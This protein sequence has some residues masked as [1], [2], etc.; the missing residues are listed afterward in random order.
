VAGAHRRPR[1]IAEQCARVQCWSPTEACLSEARLSNDAQAKIQWGSRDP[2]LD[3]RWRATS[4][5]DVST[6]AF[7]CLNAPPH[8]H[9]NQLTPAPTAPAEARA[10]HV[11]AAICVQVGHGWEKSRMP[12]LASLGELFYSPS[13]TPHLTNPAQA[14]TCARGVGHRVG[15]QLSL[16]IRHHAPLRLDQGGGAAARPAPLREHGSV[17]WV[18]NARSLGQGRRAAR[19]AAQGGPLR[20]DRVGCFPREAMGSRHAAVGTHHLA[21]LLLALMPWERCGPWLNHVNVT[22]P[23]KHS[24]QCVGWLVG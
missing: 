14:V 19:L 13:S 10:A 11:T 17:G 9:A 8:L 21:D 4:R 12:R 1:D 24:R 5:A 2:C 20:G 7:D 6:S 23:L 3:W 16:Q 18:V 22:A 15:L